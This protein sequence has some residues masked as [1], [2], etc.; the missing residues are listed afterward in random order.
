MATAYHGLPLENIL[1]LNL[2]YPVLDLV[3]RLSGYT[4]FLQEPLE[5]RPLFAP[6]TAKVPDLCKNLLRCD[7]H[8]QQCNR[9]LI[10]SGHKAIVNR[11]YITTCPYGVRFS[12]APVLINRGASAA[13]LVGGYTRTEPWTDDQIAQIKKIATENNL[14]LDEVEQW[15]AAYPISTEEHLFA[16][17][18]FIYRSASYLM[19][20]STLYN[21]QYDLLLSPD[22]AVA[23]Q[24]Y[25]GASPFFD[26]LPMDPRF[27][28][29]YNAQDERNL[30][31]AIA[32]GKREEAEAQL[33]NI[34]SKLFTRLPR[35]SLEL[36]GRL[37]ELAVLITRAPLFWEGVSRG[38]AVSLQVQPE[39]YPPVG[40]DVYTFRQWLFTVMEQILETIDRKHEDA[41]TASVIRRIILYINSNLDQKLT[42]ES[43]AVEMN[44]SPQHLN[45]MFRTEMNMSIS[46]YIILAR[47]EAAKRLLRV[48]DLSVTEIAHN[49]CFWDS[50]HFSK[51]FKKYTGISPTDYRQQE[52][53]QSVSGDNH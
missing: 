26:E 29:P 43:I 39:L 41:N 8:R 23:R 42:L 11:N 17:S 16:V 28:G 40:R 52:A 38:E 49:F 27:L 1:D 13:V 25:R 31:E 51:T 36:K 21:R 22:L 30:I 5:K 32:L 2:I 6:Q 18:D 33:E 10:T 47:V 14:R 3:A 7:D 46:D 24:L 19:S 53:S 48:S 15:L 35:G 4:V 12:M 44:F 50:T 45:R 37:M 34:L 20:I 9:F